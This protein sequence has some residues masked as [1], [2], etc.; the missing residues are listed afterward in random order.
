MSTCISHHG[1]FS[2]HEPNADYTCTLCGVLDED[3]LI[4]ELQQARAE[5]ASLTGERD[6]LA[7]QAS[8]GEVE[9]DQLR[10]DVEHVRAERDQLGQDYVRVMTERD[11]A[12]AALDPTVIAAERAE[13][14]ALRAEVVA[15]RRDRKWEADRANEAARLSADARDRADDLARQIEKLKEKLAIV[16][17]DRTSRDA[18]AVNLGLRYDLSEDLDPYDAI[19]RYLQKVILQRNE[20]MAERGA[21]RALLVE[22]TERATMAE[23]NLVGCEESR[24]GIIERHNE[25]ARTWTTER[26]KAEALLVEEQQAHAATREELAETRGEAEH[27]VA[28]VVGPNRARD[29]LSAKLA[30]GVLRQGGFLSPTGAIALRKALAQS[31]AELERQRPV[32]EAA[33]AWRADPDGV[34][35]WATSRA[36]VVAVDA[37]GAPTPGGD[38]EEAE[39]RH[40]EATRPTDGK[41]HAWTDGQWVPIPEGEPDRAEPSGFGSP[42]E[43]TSRAATCS[44][45][46][47]WCGRCLGCN[48][49]KPCE[50]GT[51]GLHYWPAREPTPGSDDHPSGT[52]VAHH[53][54]STACLHGEHDY[55]RCEVAG[56][57]GKKKPGCCK[58]CEAPCRCACHGA[59]TPGEES[60]T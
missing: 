4:F 12:V 45:F 54:L 13:V 37:L 27:V 29:L 21:A 46:C 15:L 14:Q 22:M 41:A 47:E 19:R 32:I 1:E 55:C 39:R 18:W 2:S 58:F 42:D 60:G 24:R 49:D 38:A 11:A 31:E 25:L 35:S 30:E 51:D 3:A 7:L 43:Y 17:D 48:G 23:L 5:L 26:D 6:L 33:R 9:I 59:P 52:S 44:E 50:K 34:G 40:A 36:L 53:Y 10:A 28:E 16:E 20:I 8:S 57:G 56:S